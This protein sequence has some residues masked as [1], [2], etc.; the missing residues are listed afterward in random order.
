MEPII[1]GILL[2][3]GLILPLGVQ[4]VF[5]FSQGAT[6]PTILKPYLQRLPPRFAIHYSFY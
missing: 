5:I 6:Q 1:H 3:F 2:A 4:N